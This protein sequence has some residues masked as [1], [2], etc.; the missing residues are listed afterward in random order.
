MR[1]N[2]WPL[3]LLAVALS[4]MAGCQIPQSPE[5]TKYVE[6]QKHYDEVNGL[7][8]ADLDEVFG[9]EGECWRTDQAATSCT[10]TCEISVEALAE[11]L[12][13][14]GEVTGPCD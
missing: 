1:N 6:C 13:A 10:S 5:C 4:A 2:V 8:T 14:S 12:A 11:G 7:E 3:L 9:P